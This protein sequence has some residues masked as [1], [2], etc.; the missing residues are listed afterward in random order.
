[1][2]MFRIGEFS[3]MSKTTVKTLRYYDEIGLLKPGETDRYTGYRFYSTE[4]LVRLHRIQALRQ[5]GLSIDEIKLILAGHDATG[6]LL[7][8]Q[9]ELVSQLA[10]GTD[11]LSRIDFILQ[12][13]EKESFMNYFLYRAL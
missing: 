5:V 6:I 11:Q 3:K 8:R 2:Q 1:M 7:K 12:R 9:A 4:Q 10:E 13:N